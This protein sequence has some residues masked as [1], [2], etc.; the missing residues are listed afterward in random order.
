MAPYTVS[1]HNAQ[2]ALDYLDT[3]FGYCDN[4]LDAGPNRRA[5]R[6]KAC[7]LPMITIGHM[8]ATDADMLATV[9]ASEMA[10]A[11][12]GYDFQP[13]AGPALASSTDED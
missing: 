4:S 7:G 1:S 3:F 6:L 5:C 11:Q 9:G 12:D 10:L 13:D 2:A 8:S